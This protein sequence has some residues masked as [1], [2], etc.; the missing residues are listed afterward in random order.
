MSCLIS[1]A[2]NGFLVFIDLQKNLDVKP[3]VVERLQGILEANLTSKNSP[4]IFKSIETS[5]PKIASRVTQKPKVIANSKSTTSPEKGIKKLPC[6]KV[7]PSKANLQKTPSASPH[8]KY[9][10]Q[11][12]E[13]L[14]IIFMEPF[15]FCSAF[16]SV[17]KPKRRPSL[18][19]EP[20][21]IDSSGR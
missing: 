12:V 19:P 3:D 16:R 15:F 14:R 11:W 10:Y 7:S 21:P 6:K 17:S 5:R 8:S 2:Y 20:H 18:S 9:L 13:L 1:V 4:F